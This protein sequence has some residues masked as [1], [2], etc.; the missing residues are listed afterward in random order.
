MTLLMCG[1]PASDPAVQNAARFVRRSTLSLTGTYELSL[2][3]MFLDQL[4][5]PQDRELIRTLECHTCLGV[6][7]A[8]I[9]NDRK[10]FLMIAVFV[11]VVLGAGIALALVSM[12]DLR[13]RGPR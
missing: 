12:I 8:A 9:G 6:R 5:D 4:G 10:S 13:R 1:V 3:I 11:A 7:A 2:A